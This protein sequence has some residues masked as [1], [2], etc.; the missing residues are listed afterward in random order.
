[1]SQNYDQFIQKFGVE[2]LEEIK[3]LGGRHI[4][5]SLGILELGNAN[6]QT[7]RS[8]KSEIWYLV[9]DFI[10]EIAKEE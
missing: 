7:K 10:E 6:D 9:E 8:V 4:A 3:R 1:M 2:K 5:K